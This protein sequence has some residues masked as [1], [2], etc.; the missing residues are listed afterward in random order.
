MLPEKI[1]LSKLER[2]Y[3]RADFLFGKEYIDSG[4]LRANGIVSG[5]KETL[6]YKYYYK[7]WVSK[8]LLF[9]PPLLLIR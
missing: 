8:P 9:E 6:S 3:A 5:E 2:K 4:K 1:E 7:D